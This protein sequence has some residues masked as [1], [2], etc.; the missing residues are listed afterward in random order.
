MAKI[1]LFIA[2]P[3]A[4]RCQVTPYV[5]NVFLLFWGGTDSQIQVYQLIE[6]SLGHTLLHNFCS[7][8][9]PTY[10]E[11]GVGGR[12]LRWAGVIYPP[13]SK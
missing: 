7:A 4:Q 1:R 9:T 13:S 10:S 5:V 2:R 6:A 11:G 3:K 12:G 8:N